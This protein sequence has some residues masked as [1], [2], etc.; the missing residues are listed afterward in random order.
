MV[1]IVPIQAPRNYTADVTLRKGSAA[2][3]SLPV[4]IKKTDVEADYP[5][6]T[7]ELGQRI[8]RNQNWTPLLCGGVGVLETEA[9]GRADLQPISDSGTGLS[10]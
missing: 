5:Y 1:R 9:G 8:S 3:S 10:R 6:L 7:K 4:L 2:D